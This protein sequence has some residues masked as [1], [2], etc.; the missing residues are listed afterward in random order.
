MTGRDVCE[1]HVGAAPGRAARGEALGEAAG[2]AA[3]GEGL[4]ET[5]P[6]EEAAAHAPAHPPTPAQLLEPRSVSPRGAAPRSRLAPPAAKGPLA[7]GDPTEGPPAAGESEQ[8]PAKA[9]QVVGQQEQA[10]AH[11]DKALSVACEPAAVAMLGEEAAELHCGVCDVRATSEEQ[12][13]SHREGKRHARHLAMAELSTTMGAKPNPGQSLTGEEGTPDAEALRCDLCQVTAPTPVHKEY[14]LRGQKHQ[15][16]EKQA[17]VLDA[18]GQLAAESVEAVLGDDDA[19]LPCLTGASAPPSMALLVEQGG[20]GGTEPIQ[21]PEAA[22][23]GFDGPRTISSV[24]ANIAEAAAGAGAVEEDADSLP[25]GADERL[26]S[27]AAPPQRS[28]SKLKSVRFSENYG[29]DPG[30]GGTSDSDATRPF[31]P[32]LATSGGSVSLAAQ[33]FCPVCGI[34]ATSHANLEDHM[35]G[36]RH[37][38]RLQ[39]IRN[40]PEEQRMNHLERIASGEWGGRL[41]RRD[42]GGHGALETCLP[43]VRIGAYNLPS[44]MDLRTFLEDM[45]EI[46]AKT[47]VAPASPPAPASPRRAAPRPSRLGQAASFTDSAPPAGDVAMPPAGDAVVELGDEASM[48]MSAEE[49]N[50]MVAG[51]DADADAKVGEGN[52]LDCSSKEGSEADQEGS[53]EGLGEEEGSAEGGAEGGPRVRHE[54]AVCGITTTSAAHLEAHNRG[55]KHKRRIEVAGARAPRASAH[56]CVI[57]DITT[58]SAQHMAMHVAGKAHRRRVATG[59][60]PA[61]VAAAAAAAAAGGGGDAPGDGSSGYDSSEAAWANGGAGRTVRGGRGAGGGPHGAARPPSADGGGAS[62]AAGHGSAGGGGSDAR[63]AWG[64]HSEG[65]AHR[66]RLASRGSGGSQQMARQWSAVLGG[67]PMG[68]PHGGPPLHPLS[69]LPAGYSLGYY[70]QAFYAQGQPAPMQYWSA[71]GGGSYGG[72]GGGG[73]GFPMATTVAFRPAAALAV[74]YS[75]GVPPGGYAGPYNCDLCGT[76]AQDLQDYRTHIRG[77]SHTRRLNLPHAG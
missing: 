43:T 73:G 51:A 55:R 50:L 46:G 59:H 12:L 7:E 20:G 45:Q 19:P 18:Q 13:A 32:A 77:K 25:G 62:S 5:P 52:G 57:C 26:R 36:R 1:G 65:Q 27:A 34:I 72:E 9:A 67:A 4:P 68:G 76:T 69:P 8:V 3:A 63:E 61:S 60:M 16:R 22:L 28:L 53:G 30:S 64:G 39:Y 74:P 2:E 23:E 31:R 37:A 41:A 75:H 47:P 58:T 17:Q 33:H 38:R 66:G 56:H 44:S 71:W 6:R 14:H 11:D 42:S 10:A 54:C 24:F 48:E 49:G 29:S 15:R 35:K 70:P 21:A 40:M